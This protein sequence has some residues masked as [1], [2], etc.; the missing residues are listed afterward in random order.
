MTDI[1]PVYDGRARPPVQFRCVQ[2]P[3]LPALTPEWEIPSGVSVEEF[4]GEDEMVILSD[5]NTERRGTLK[6]G[7]WIVED[8][9]DHQ[10]IGY[11]PT[12]FFGVR[13]EDFDE[14]IEKG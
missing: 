1:L 3:E 14:M 9:R 10:I 6:P 13:A 2:I 5:W 11:R 7:D 12:V 4:C 8:L